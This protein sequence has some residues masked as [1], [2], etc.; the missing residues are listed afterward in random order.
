MS[1]FEKGTEQ[2]L[3]HQFSKHPT[4]PLAPTA[5][6]RQ[7]TLQPVPRGLEPGSES[8]WR[9]NK[10]IRY[11]IQEK[12]EAEIEGNRTPAGLCLSITSYTI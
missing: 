10:L 3:Q 11:E 12:G 4:V 2:I 7:R 8:G 6:H 1:V 5:S 9:W